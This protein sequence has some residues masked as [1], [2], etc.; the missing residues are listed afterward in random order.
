MVLGVCR[1]VLGNSH[2]AEDA[3]QATFLVLIRKADSLKWPDLLANWL[4]GVAYRTALEAKAASA[5]RRLKERLVSRLPGQPA[6]ETNLYNDLLPVLDQELN[7]L[8]DRFRVPVV[9]CDLEGRT[10]R[11]A[12]RQLGIPEG[13]LSGRLTT[14]HRRLARRLALRGL[15]LA[16]GVLAAVLSPGVTSAN[17]PTALVASTISAGT[18]ITAG[19]GVLSTQVAALTEGVMKAMFL[20]K[21]KSPRRFY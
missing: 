8:P 19:T 10:R 2:D 5:R 4:F 18:L 16:G 6:P 13:T 11:E 1:R 9:L 20:I 21:L 15:T 3:F 14:A 12:A 17:V 7:R